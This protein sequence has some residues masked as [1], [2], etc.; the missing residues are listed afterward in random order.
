MLDS[1]QGVPFVVLE[2]LA[3]GLPETLI[4]IALQYALSADDDW[5]CR[6]LAKLAP[7]LSGAWLHQAITHVIEMNGL[8]WKAVALA[9]LA[10]QLPDDYVD[11]EEV[12][13]I[14]VE[15]A[16]SWPLQSRLEGVMPD[17][18]PQ[19][20]ERLRARAVRSALDQ[21]RSGLC[22]YQRLSGEEFDRLYALLGVLRGPELEQLYA[23]LGKEVC[24]PRVRARAQAAVIEHAGRKHPAGF[25]AD[26]PPLHRDWP[27]DFDRAGLMDLTAGAAWWIDRNSHG[28][29]I[30]EIVEAILDVAPLVAIIPAFLAASVQCPQF[31]MSGRSQPPGTPR[32]TTS[33]LASSNSATHRLPLIS[34]VHMRC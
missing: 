27:G 24:T 8:G 25:L 2:E 23:L 6:A 30:D 12:L 31:G 15:G 26:G 1:G 17:L 20:P 16:C 34:A 5:S 28:T 22:S 18:I 29:E 33:V 9:P 10:R 32:L 14:A 4:A 3:P 7:R 11:R 19:L 13:T 21:A